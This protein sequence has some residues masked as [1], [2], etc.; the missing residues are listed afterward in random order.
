V[1]T[2]VFVFASVPVSSLRWLQVGIAFIELLQLL[3]RLC[4]ERRSSCKT[5]VDDGTDAPQ[6]RLRIVPQRHQHFWSL[7]AHIKQTYLPIHTLLPT[8]PNR[9]W[10]GA[11]GSC[12]GQINEVTSGPVSTGMSDCIRVQLPVREIYLSPTNHPGTQSGHPSV[13]IHNEY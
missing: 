6:V 3:W 5:L 10:F 13:G 11:V 2:S 9:W 7:L 12:I 1:I 4:L 8:A